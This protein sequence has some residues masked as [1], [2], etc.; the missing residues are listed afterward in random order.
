M[1]QD[2]ARQRGFRNDKGSMIRALKELGS[3][4][5]VLK[6]GTIHI[7]GQIIICRVGVGGASWHY[8]MATSISGLYTNGE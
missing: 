2:Q 6:L 4:T 1:C 8:G 5:G 7:L 3:N